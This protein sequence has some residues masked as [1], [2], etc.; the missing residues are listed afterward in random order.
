MFIGEYN[1]SI[2]DKARVT[3]P[4][5]FREGLGETFYL[6]KGFDE[7]IFVYSAEEWKKFLEKLEK[8]AMKDKKHRQVQ[9]F[10]FT[11]A[12]ECNFDK[13]GRVLITPPLRA[14]AKIEKDVAVVGVSNRIE[15]WAKEKWDEYNQNMDNIDELVDGLDDFDL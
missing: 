14:Y 11:S 6:C 2:D 12:Y 1:H 13:Q 15:I 10:F 7:C 3:M 4:S 9:R 5:K 8:N